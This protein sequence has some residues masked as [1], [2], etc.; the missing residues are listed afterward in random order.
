MASSHTVLQR[1]CEVN[2]AV[3]VNWII[4]VM[5]QVN[6]RGF[7]QVSA[8]SPGESYSSQRSERRHERCHTLTWH[9]WE[10]QGTRHRSPRFFPGTLL[11]SQSCK[12]GCA[13]GQEKQL[14]DSMGR[15]RSTQGQTGTV[16][17][18]K[19][20]LRVWGGCRSDW[21]FAERQPWVTLLIF[22]EK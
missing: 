5:V 2:S 13:L 12:V 22:S 20:C 15:L 19:R 8:K 6:N 3:N 7:A 16:V 18:R 10:R 9:P 14:S 17:K 21:G 11:Q 1:W 4:Y